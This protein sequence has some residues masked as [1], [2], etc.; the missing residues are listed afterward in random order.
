MCDKTLWD[1]LQAAQQVKRARVGAFTRAMPL[2]AIAG[3]ASGH[4][5]VAAV[6]IAELASLDAH[7]QKLCHQSRDCCRLLPT[8][9][10]S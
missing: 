10:R 8:A 5:A 2:V 7:F 9:A 4:I 6:S 1:N 3:N